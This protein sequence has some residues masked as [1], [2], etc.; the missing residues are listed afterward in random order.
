[1]TLLLSKQGHN[2]TTSGEFE[3]VR[4]MK[5]KTCFVSQNPAKEEKSLLTKRETFVLPDGRPIKVNID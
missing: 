3:I 4:M 2:F 5:E 1:L